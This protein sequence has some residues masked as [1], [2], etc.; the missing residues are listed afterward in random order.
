MSSENEI[1]VLLVEDSEE[2]VL[3]SRILL[4]QFGQ[5]IIL[6]VAQTIIE[7]EKLARQLLTV[8]LGLTVVIISDLHLPFEGYEQGID[9]TYLLNL[10]ADEIRD[11][12]LAQCILIALSSDMTPQRVAL[13]SH[14]TGEHWQKPLNK[15]HLERLRVLLDDGPLW[16]LP[17]T[18]ASSHSPLVR[19]VMSVARK[20]WFSLHPDQSIQVGKS[21]LGILTNAISLS[22][23]EYTEGILLVRQYGG[24]PVLIRFLRN[25]ALNAR[26]SGPERS[27]FYDLLDGISQSTAIKRSQLTRRRSRS[28]LNTLYKHIGTLVL[29]D[30]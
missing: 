12:K 28:V 13:G 2:H 11:N 22:A 26:L 6:H 16:V 20:M 21:I 23:A 29:G 18:A 1:H 19:D 25:H 8:D 14:A 9:G 27:F 4:K 3:L 7:G 30:K 15:N 10:L 24:R 5:P 17:N